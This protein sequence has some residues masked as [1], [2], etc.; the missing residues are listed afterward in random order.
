MRDID[1]IEV[2]YL[3]S[4]EKIT[5]KLV[6]CSPITRLEALQIAEIIESDPSVFKVKC[7]TTRNTYI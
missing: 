2:V 4:S 1:Y 5:T 7:F 3:Q 6:L